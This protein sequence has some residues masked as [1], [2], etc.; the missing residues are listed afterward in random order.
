MQRGKLIDFGLAKF[1]KA[2]KIQKHSVKRPKKYSC[3]RNCLHAA[4]YVCTECLAKKEKRAPRSG[5][6]GFRAPEVLLKYSRQTS[7]IDVWACGVVLLSLLSKKYP[8]FN[9]KD[10]STALAEIIAIFGSSVCVHAANEIGIT[11][12]LSERF[13]EHEISTL[14]RE[15][16]DSS[17]LIALLTNLLDVNCLTRISAEEAL[18]IIAK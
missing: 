6:P 16:N 3:A 1:A 11:L 17:D 5:T 18:S 8:F 14:C 13:E 7:A 4:N 10:D 2:P 9:A 15:K 12:T